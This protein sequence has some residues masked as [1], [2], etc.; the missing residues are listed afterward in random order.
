MNW[1]NKHSHALQALGALM[2]AVVAI[3]ALIG[4]KWQ[5]DSQERV[6]QSQLALETYRSFIALSIAH[7][8]Y[9]DPGMCPEFSAAESVAYG[10]YLEYLLYTAEQV[11]ASD[12]AWV[13]TFEGALEPHLA[14]L[15]ATADW[16]G[17]DPI[18]Q[19]II[20][21]TRTANCGMMPECG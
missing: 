10:D 20:Q 12:D 14:T 19:S 2:T 13:T 6:A 3:A 16:G 1:L 17:Y 11:T 18:V 21:R 4:V 8:Q 15:C 7:P 9:S 5:L